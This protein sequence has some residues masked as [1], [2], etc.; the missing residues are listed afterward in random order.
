MGRRSDIERFYVLLEKLRQKTGLRRLA[1]CHGRMEWHRQGVYFFFEDGEKRESSS[2]LRVVRVGT[3]GTK[4]GADTTLWDRLRQHRGTLGGEFA[5]GGNHRGSIFRLHVGTAIINQQNLEV[6]NWSKGIS[7]S[8]DIRKAEYWMECKVSQVIG[9]MPFLWLKVEDP[10]GPDSMREYIKKNA[11]A[12]LSNY[13][14]QPIDEASTT[15]L[16]RYCA[17]YEMERLVQDM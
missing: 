14:R 15:W 3:H 9:A 10:A 13:Y 1:K 8:R 6:P 4:K 11:I 5:G 7:A 2:D 17:H 16:G 12:L